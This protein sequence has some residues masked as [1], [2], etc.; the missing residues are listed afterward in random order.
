MNLEKY[1]DIRPYTDAEV[2]DAV[3]RLP[4]SPL[5]AELSEYFFGGDNKKLAEI[6][7]NVKSVESFQED[8]MA[9]VIIAIIDKSTTGLTYT[10]LENI[11]QDVKHLI[12][13]NHRDIILDPAFIQIIFYLNN[14]STTQIAVGD[15]LISS[16][17]IEDIIRSNRMIKVIR[18]S[19]AKEMYLSSKI[20]SE[21]I[22]DCVTLNYSSVWIAQGNGRT[23][24]GIDFT[25]QGLLK[26]LDMSGKGD[27]AKSF[28]ELHILPMS[29]SYQYEPCD[30]LK[31]RELF[32]TR[33]RKYIKSKGEDTF[34]IITGV[35]QNKGGVHIH[36]N[37]TIHREELD[38]ISELN[39][40]DR[41]KALAHTLDRSIV[42][43]YKLWNT[44]YI[45]YDI[46]NKRDQYR[47]YYTEKER[48]N[49]IGYCH[50]GLEKMVG[51]DPE[52]TGNT[53]ELKEI[54]YSIYA[55]PLDSLIK[56]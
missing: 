50:A 6:L 11:N 55:N 37:P 35:K 12:M 41:F 8:V 3:R 24:N 21:Y 38:N 19:T 45:A 1:N 48:E 22:R 29:I 16:P 28:D 47:D 15:N 23:K 2:E 7:S 13:S 4:E 33:R 10:G 49:F 40:N 18:N 14:L 9:K 27:F 32:I 43:S 36:F 46:L 51:H 42:S 52:L 54:F 39:K 25:E 53:E 56:L 31:V 34:S 5:L 44:N 30:F 26:M 20:L 17:F